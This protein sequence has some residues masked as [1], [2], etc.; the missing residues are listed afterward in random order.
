[1]SRFSKDRQVAPDQIHNLPQHDLV[2]F[3]SRGRWDTSASV[4]SSLQLRR[5]L[6]VRENSATYFGYA[7]PSSGI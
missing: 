5:L 6:A 1:M 4:P 7:G 2:H 3:R